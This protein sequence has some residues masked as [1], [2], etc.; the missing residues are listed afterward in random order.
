MAN[1]TLKQTTTKTH[2]FQFQ[3]QLHLHFP[4]TPTYPSI[5][6]SI[7]QSNPN[8]LASR[9]DQSKAE[10]PGFTTVKQQ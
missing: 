5:N 6:Q 2:S 3:L 10:T 9:A 7:N 1:V 4:A 8:H